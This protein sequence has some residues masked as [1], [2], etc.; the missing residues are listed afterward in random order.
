MGGARAELAQT[1]RAI[2]QGERLEAEAAEL[3]A[4]LKVYAADREAT[5]CRLRVIRACLGEEPADLQ[6]IRRRLT[7][8]IDSKAP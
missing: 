8:I 7:E 5:M 2:D 3:E 4:R 1:K 6:E